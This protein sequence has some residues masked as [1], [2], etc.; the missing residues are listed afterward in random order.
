MRLRNLVTSTAFLTGAIYAGSLSQ[1]G[2]PFLSCQD[3]CAPTSGCTAECVPVGPNCA[4]RPGFSLFSL[5]HDHDDEDD[6]RDSKARRICRCFAP[7][8]P[9]RG[10]TAIAMP[11]R[12]SGEFAAFRDEEPETDQESATTDEQCE[13]LEEDLTRLTLIVEELVKAHQQDRGDLTRLTIAVEE[14]AKSQ[15]SSQDDMTRMSLILEQ[16]APQQ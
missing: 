2:W 12:L 1:A 6:D 8:E 4:Y 16:I 5:F 3:G 11:A 7:G 15:K 9:P 14:L 10:E 13:E